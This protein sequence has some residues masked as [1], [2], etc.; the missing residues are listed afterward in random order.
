MNSKKKP[1]AMKITSSARMSQSQIRQTTDPSFPTIPEKNNSTENKS[2]SKH[3]KQI[4]PIELMKISTSQNKIAPANPSISHSDP[5]ILPYFDN[6]RQKKRLSQVFLSDYGSVCEI[7]DNLDL[8]GKTVL[9]IGPGRGIITKILVKTAKKVVALEIDPELCSL[10]KE[11]ITSKN[12]EINCADALQA[13]LNYPVIIGFLPYHISSP[14]LF[15]ILNS[16][17]NEAILCVQ[18]EFALRLIAEPNSENYSKLS[19]M[20]QNKADIDFLSIVPRGAFTPVPKVD[21]ALVYI[22]KNEK[23]KINENLISCLFQHKNQTIKNALAHSASNLSLPKE[24]LREF[25]RKI[26]SDRRVRTLALD[27]L[28]KL[29]IDFDSFI[30]EK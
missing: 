24:K 30:S 17:F 4:R 14:L 2:A 8:A 6:F 20:A 18:K 12:F 7:F 13:S 1:K 29:S 15:K 28:S 25:S 26:K 10:L 19:V 22:V 9:E 5:N 11:Q 27:E 16:D 21:S 23:F 3:E